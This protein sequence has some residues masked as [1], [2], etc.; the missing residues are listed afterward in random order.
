MMALCEL[1]EYVEFAAEG[2]RDS[3]GTL[4]SNKIFSQVV[5]QIPLP[6]GV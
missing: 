1:R 3:T 4:K 2:A 5:L 6:R